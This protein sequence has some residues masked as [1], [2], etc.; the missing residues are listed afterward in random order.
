[1]IWNDSH[2]NMLVTLAILLVIVLATCSGREAMAAT[3]MED[4]T[5]VMAQEEIA[6][7]QQGGGCKLITEYQIDILTRYI[8]QL[9]AD[10]RKIES[11]QEARRL[12]VCI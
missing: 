3:V 2:S 9:K 5:I 11:E 10:I 6:H 1:M 12:K 7:C 8:E 4:G